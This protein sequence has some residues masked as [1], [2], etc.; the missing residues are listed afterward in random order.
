MTELDR[1]GD[2]CQ[3]RGPGHVVDHDVV[4]ESPVAREGPQHE[5]RVQ[6]GNG[7]VGKARGKLEV[8]PDIPRQARSLREAWSG[9]V[10]FT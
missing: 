2:R 10:G 7:G 3:P 6:A 4:A 8:E 9:I 5:L 1:A